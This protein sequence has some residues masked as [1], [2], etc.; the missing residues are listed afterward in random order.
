MFIVLRSCSDII[1]LRK[2]ILYCEYIFFN[3]FITKCDV[4]GYS[5]R[6]I[7]F[8]VLILYYF[9]GLEQYVLYVKYVMLCYVM[10]CCYVQ[11]VLYKRKICQV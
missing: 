3:P 6:F 5:K 8:E 7:L 10:L 9:L 11:Y 1:I 4:Q 2:E